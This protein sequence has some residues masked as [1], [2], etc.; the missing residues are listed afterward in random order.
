[1]TESCVRPLLPL[2]VIYIAC[3]VVLMIKSL[4]IILTFNTRFDQIYEIANATGPR[5]QLHSQS[6]RALIGQL[7]VC[8]PSK[9]VPQ[10]RMP[11]KCPL[12]YYYTLYRLYSEQEC[13]HTRGIHNIALKG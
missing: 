1:M 10:A 6:L 7:I 12:P 8:H 2:H 3:Y 4:S 13:Q 5:A 11:T 9:L